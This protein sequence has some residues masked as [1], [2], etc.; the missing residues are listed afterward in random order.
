[1]HASG[2]AFEKTIWRV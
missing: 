1:M 2:A